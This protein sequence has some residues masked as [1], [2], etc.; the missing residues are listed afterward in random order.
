MSVDCVAIKITAKAALKGNYL[1]AA[2]VCC[3]FLFTGFIC[4]YLSAL[5]S[6]VT[7]EIIG[8][9]VNVA[10]GI[11][12][13]LPIA[14]GM[15][16]YIWRM[17]FGVKDNPLY[18]FC[19]FSS[20]RSYIKAI[21]FI[22]NFLL[23]LIM[24]LVILN[25][26]SMLLLLFSKSY[27]FE[28]FD[29]SMPIWAGSFEYYSAFLRNIAYILA[30][31]I[32]LKFYMAPVLFVADEGI[33][34]HEAMYNSSVIA[35][36]TSFDFLGLLLSLV[37]WILL[38]A[39]VLPLPFTMPLLLTCYAVHTRFSIAEYNGFISQNGAEDFAVV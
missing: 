7:G 3:V 10:M 18:V 36:K 9:I 14:L 15:L 2:A 19:W 17:L 33:D 21:K 8:K 4:Q 25:V 27:V 31:F 5:I 11:F 28:L 29:T 34:P 6:L 35:R 39:L 23:K 32:M 24:W 30:F 1:R 12:I 22:F 20:K 13:I 38:S 37:L 16:K 26:P